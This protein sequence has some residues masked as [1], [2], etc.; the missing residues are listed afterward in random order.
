MF[1]R[2]PPRPGPDPW[3]N[4]I[5]RIPLGM[6]FS[7]VPF[8]AH[9]PTPLAGGMTPH[10]PVKIFLYLAHLWDFVGGE[11]SQRLDIF[12]FPVNKYIFLF[13]NIPFTHI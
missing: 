11:T 12:W 9:P 2:L 5:S 13:F 10:P 8:H 6:F 1:P 4:R 3:Q 7:E